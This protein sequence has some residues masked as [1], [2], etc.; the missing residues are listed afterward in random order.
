[1]R[2]N[3]TSQAVY[4]NVNQTK[5]TVKA[6]TAEKPTFADI[7]YDTIKHSGAVATDIGIYSKPN[8]T[9][10]V[11]SVY[12]ILQSEWHPTLQKAVRAASEFDTTGMTEAEIYNKVESIFQDY[13]GKDCL[14]LYKI[15]SGYGGGNAFNSITGF[16]VAVHNFFLSTLQRVHD[17]QA[18]YHQVNIE[19][20]GYAGLSATQMRT[21]I[22]SQFPEN[23]TL[24]DTLLMA[25][26]L[27]EVGL[28]DAIGP[29]A[30]E[31]IFTT[32]SFGLFGRAWNISESDKFAMKNIYDEMLKQ[33]ANFEAMKANIE[34]FRRSDGQFFFNY[35]DVGLFSSL[36]VLLQQL[37]DSFGGS[38]DMTGSL[39]EMLENAKNN[40]G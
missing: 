9:K 27:M 22:R 12:D 34:S 35:D 30:V 28:E 19:R 11:E 33:P 24:K 25:W 26:E 3:G 5:K 7:F 40:R 15:Y 23:M 1:M 21:A 13:L 17:I 16:G 6:E 14:D 37:L 10:K 32:M 4:T 20:K 29:L 8:A 31:N 36:D 39:M 2:I 38:F 18:P